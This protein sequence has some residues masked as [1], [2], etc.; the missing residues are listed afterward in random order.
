MFSEADGKPANDLFL[1]GR[2]GPSLLIS[3]NNPC[4][5]SALEN[6]PAQRD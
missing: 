4:P 1:L 3:N 2:S 6:M 5:W